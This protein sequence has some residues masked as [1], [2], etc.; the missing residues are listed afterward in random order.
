M[1][2]NPRTRVGCD[3]L[4]PSCPVYGHV[5]IHAPV[6]GATTTSTPI[7]LPAMFQS[8]HPC[9]VRHLSQCHKEISMAFQSTHPCGV[10]HIAPP[11]Y[12]EGLVSIHAPVWGAT[13]PTAIAKQDFSFNPRTRVGCDNL[14]RIE[15]QIVKFQSTHPCGVRQNLRLYW[16]TVFLFQSTHP[17][18]VR[19]VVSRPTR[20][21][22]RFN[23]RT[24]VGC[25]A[26]GLI[27]RLDR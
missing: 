13:T 4:N 21:N 20:P 10:R 1:S 5:S 23:P 6:W 12:F 18:G 3:T 9:G 14:V 25:D 22:W 15:Q 26:W 27:K 8:T 2:F 19:P 16:C 7:T 11:L 17:C 24:R